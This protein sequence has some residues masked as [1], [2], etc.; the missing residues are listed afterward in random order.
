[1]F[2]TQIRFFA[3]LYIE[4]ESVKAMEEYVGRGD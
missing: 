2:N 1:M 4:N 3:P